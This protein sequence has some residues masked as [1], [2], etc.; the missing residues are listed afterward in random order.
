[1]VMFFAMIGWG[2]SWVSVKVL[3]SY[4]SAFELIFLRYLI[5]F[6]SMAP[7]LLYLKKSFKI[8]MKS[9]GIA[10][11]AAIVMIAYTYYFF[12]GTKHGTASLGGAFVTTLIPINTFIILVLFFGRAINKKDAFALF[13]GATG[14]MS[15][16][17]VWHLS[18]EEIFV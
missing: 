13:L 5:T 1:M 17:G 18:F 8:D 16:L 3:S 4:I 14:V 6:I 15:I 10:L 9:L 2:S 12:L 7:V 11:I